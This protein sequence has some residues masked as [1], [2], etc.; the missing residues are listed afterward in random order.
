ML[1]VLARISDLLVANETKDADQARPASLLLVIIHAQS[2][3]VLIFFFC[4]MH[5]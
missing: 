4:T 2:Q 5:L 3:R 1:Q